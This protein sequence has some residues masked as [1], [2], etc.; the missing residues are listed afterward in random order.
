M[1][2][3]TVEIRIRAEGGGLPYGGESLGLN[4]AISGVALEDIMP[5]SR[6][7]LDPFDLYRIHQQGERRQRL[8]EMFAS[9]LAREITEGLYK[10]A[11]RKP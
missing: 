7:P 4:H 10:L 1:I 6:P 11:E 2:K 9:S 3:L 8:V 5:S